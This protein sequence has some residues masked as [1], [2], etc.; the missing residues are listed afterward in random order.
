MSEGPAPPPE[1]DDTP[2]PLGQFV[3]VY[4]KM[5]RIGWAPHEV[6]RME[7]PVVGRFL[8]GPVIRGSRG[9]ITEADKPGPTLPSGQSRGG[10]LSPSDDHSL[11]DRI[12]AHKE[13]ERQQ[14]SADAPPPA[15]D[16]PTE[17]A[18][19]WYEDG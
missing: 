9:L 16:P 15:D 7:L 19:V 1:P 10:F 3:G 14:E 12:A 2:G 17:D 5:G 13:R 8:R 6:D 18:P 4:A 11:S